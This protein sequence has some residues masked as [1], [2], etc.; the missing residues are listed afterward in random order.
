MRNEI[1]ARRLE[2]ERRWLS[3]EAKDVRHGDADPE[4][5][6][7]VRTHDYAAIL[8]LTEDGRV[9]LVRQF[10]PAIEVRSLELPSG[11]VEPDESP[12][13]TV[14]R[15]LV[16]ETGCE[17]AGDVIRIGA[18][19]VDSGRMQTTVHA[20]FT[21]GVRVVADS[22]SGEE[23]DLEVV[24]V[25]PEELRALVVEGEFRMAA[26]LALLGAALVRGLL[27]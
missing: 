11:L 13:E 17:A 27:P 22:P 16:E 9:P 20:F 6:Y 25:V 26:H 21:S 18:F 3:V 2:Y 19:D 1:L 23:A 7:S 12:E 24:F 8:A 5:Y 4:T 10:R 14:R 15:E